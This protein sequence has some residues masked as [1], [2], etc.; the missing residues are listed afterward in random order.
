[1]SSTRRSTETE[2]PSLRAAVVDDDAAM[3]RLLATVLE[4]RGHVARA[5][6]RGAD[7]LDAAVE[8]PF[9][10]VVCDFNMP[11][12][13]GDELCNALRERLGL[14]APPVVMVSGADDEDR[15]GRALDAGA[16]HYV[17]KPFAPGELIAIVERAAR[18]ARVGSA[19]GAPV[20]LG[21]WRI[22]TEIGRGGMGQVYSAERGGRVCA[23]K[24]LPASFTSVEDHLRFRRELDVLASLEHPGIP[25][26][27]ETGSEGGWVFYAME[28][29]PG[30]A[31]SEEIAR[32]P[33]AW[34]R[35]VAIARDLATTLA[36]VH[37]RGLVHRDV[38]PQNVIVRPE[39]QSVLVDFGLARRPRDLALT[40]S[41]SVLGTPAYIAP[42][43][44][45]EAPG[46]PSDIFALGVTL[47][48]ALLGAHPL[49]DISGQSPLGLVMRFA[50]GE[51]PPL[52]RSDAPR[53][54]G[55]LVAR[56]SNPR[57]GARPT[58]IEASATLARLLQEVTA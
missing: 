1:M 42:E 37:G 24:V 53:A 30:A 47:H 27:I 10:V 44:F 46:A 9:D 40:A 32:G 7:A 25:R 39:G 28:L 13:P 17:K 50:R 16:R 56:M 8:Q 35:A 41:D 23:L 34:R 29:I 3:R 54:L 4:K 22:L 45:E 2:R 51:I 43:V 14:R 18:G 11:G 15:I 26:L 52:A 33:L 5:F 20:Q 38:K 48:E 6:E 36:F 49:G 31:L 58:S 55:E 21:G 57:P 12:L 19:S